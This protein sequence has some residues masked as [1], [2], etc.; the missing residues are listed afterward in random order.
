MVV[1]DLDGT[2]HRT[3]RVLTTAVRDAADACGQPRPA[4]DAVRAALGLPTLAFCTELFPA[5]DGAALQQLA[6]ALR[7]RERRL[8]PREAELFAGTAAML[9]TLSGAGLELAICSNGSEQYVSAVLR[10]TRIAQHFRL[11]EGHRDN[12]SKRQ[13]LAALLARARPLDALFVGDTRHDWQAARDNCL[14]CIS[15]RYGYGSPAAAD[16]CAESPADVVPHVRRWQVFAQ[17]ERLFGERRRSGPLVIG[18]S[19]PDAAGKTRFTQGLTAHLAARGHSMTVIH[20]D[21]FHNPREL[22]YQGHDEVESY[23]S[24]AFNLELLAGTLLTPIREQ[25]RLDHSLTLLDLSTD[26]FTR[27]RHYTVTPDSIVIVE[28]TL[29]FRPPT[30]ELLELRIV[31]DA[32]EPEILRRAVARHSDQ[33]ATAV[34]ERYRQKYLEVQRR[35]TLHHR[36][37]ERADVVIDNSDFDAP[38]IIRIS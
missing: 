31:L 25:G 18:L 3:D 14:P 33:P 20:V 26:Q 12:R 2:L 13:A 10:A 29:L 36:P 32:S 28:G 9:S 37:R 11:I 22:R 15:V 35:Y 30:D 23:L 6:A 19:G 38:Q 24:H 34:T 16:F 17:L 21:D 27:Q 1:F 7:A 8:I 5:A 4:D